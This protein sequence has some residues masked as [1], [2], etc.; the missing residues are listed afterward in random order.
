MSS[1]QTAPSRG[2]HLA[3]WAAEL[4][5]TAMLLFVVVSAVTVDFAPGSPLRRLLPSSSL[6]LL[7]TGL[8]I[9]GS[10][11]LYAVA[12]PGKRSGAHLNPAV[13]LAFWMMGHVHRHDL[14]GYWVSQFLGAILG[15]AAG[16]AAWRG[17]A[18]S[19]RV[20]TTRPGPGIPPWLAAVAEFGMTTILLLVIFWLL[21][22]RRTRRLVPV[23]VWLLVA[24]F[25]WQL[26]PVSGTSLNPARSLGPAL[27][28]G[29][30]EWMWIYFG[31]PALGAGAAAAVA[32]L[33]GHEFKP[34]SAKLF[35]DPRY[36]NIFGTRPE[37]PL[38]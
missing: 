29:H 37:R 36:K 27:F 18:L 25:V 7:L 32:H 11:S 19:V 5:G 9:A 16:V 2:L 38:R 15:T 35:H 4:V 34:L 10:G 17:A 24:G 14:I 1:H 12:P 28:E 8:V 20:A 23:V 22:R 26:A 3:E 31:G 30:L 6:R 13:T 33:V 21:A